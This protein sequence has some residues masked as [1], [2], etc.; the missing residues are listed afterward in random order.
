MSEEKSISL[1]NYITL[2]IVLIVSIV[3]VVYFYMWYSEFEL[4]KNSTPILDEYFYVINYNELED[5]LIENKNVILY[6]STLNNNTTRKFESKLKTFLDDYSFNKDIIYLDLTSIKKN[7]GLYQSILSKYN[8][9]NLPCIVI[10]NNGNIIDSY[11][12]V[13]NNYEVDLLIS[14]LRIKGVLDD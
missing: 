12:V 2:S 6:V 3:L 14:Y 4:N 10:F 13:D 7:N 1:K 5:Y 11:S 9:I 8:L